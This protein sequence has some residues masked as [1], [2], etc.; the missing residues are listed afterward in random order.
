MS[1]RP[2]L[3]ALAGNWK[4][5]YRLH[6][7]WLPEKTHDSVSACSVELRV[8]GQFLAME[9]S[10][11][12]ESKP[13]EGVMIIGCDEKSDAVQALWTDS[14]HMS[15]KF[16]IC[17]GTIDEKGQVKMKG[18]Y[19]VPDHPDWGWRTEII[20]ETNLLQILMYNVSPEGDEDIAVESSYSRE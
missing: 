12:Y 5:N 18:F 19:S 14:W 6:T 10:W 17:N 11:E 7:L 16:M 20:P 4:G 8:N 3:A 2:S 9:Y 1:V 13:Q 15:H